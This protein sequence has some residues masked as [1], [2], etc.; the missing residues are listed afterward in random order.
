MGGPCARHRTYIREWRNE[1]NLSLRQLADRI[2]AGRPAPLISYA[3]LGRIERGI[4]PY[5]QDTL[6]AIAAALDLDPACLLAHPPEGGTPI[7]AIWA[8]LDPT[9]RRQA[10]AIIEA[11]I[12]TR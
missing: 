12:Q 10:L 6:E 1:R 4:Q 7:T 8:R 5:S 9:Q 3:S 11:L 2:N